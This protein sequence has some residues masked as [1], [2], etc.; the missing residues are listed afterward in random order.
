MD[1]IAETTGLDIDTVLETMTELEVMGYAE[2]RGG[3]CY[4]A[5]K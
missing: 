5:N 3:L 1:E 4:P 2:N